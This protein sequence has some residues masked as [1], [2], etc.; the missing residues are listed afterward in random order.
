MESMT[1]QSHLE[2]AADE[3]RR[4][5]RIAWNDAIET[6]ARVIQ[7]EVGDRQEV[8]AMARAILSLRK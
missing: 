3:R 4:V 6:A 2:S 8:D 7:D 5:Y 1:T